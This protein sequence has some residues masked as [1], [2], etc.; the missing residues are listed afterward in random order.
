MESSLGGSEVALAGRDCLHG[1]YVAACSEYPSGRTI[2]QI[3]VAETG[4][5]RMGRSAERE[6]KEERMA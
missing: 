2:W 5:E 1:S 3:E 4:I 6:V